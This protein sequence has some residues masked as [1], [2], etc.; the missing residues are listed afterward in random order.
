MGNIPKF[1]RVSSHLDSFLLK[2][3][4]LK[5][6][7]STLLSVKT[8]NSVP[9]KFHLNLPRNG[10]SPRRSLSLAVYTDSVGDNFFK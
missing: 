1:L 5:K 6:L 9:S 3:G 4:F 10:I 8:S 2:L 7:F